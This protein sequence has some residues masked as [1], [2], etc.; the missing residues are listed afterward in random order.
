MRIIALSVVPFVLLGA[1]DDPCEQLAD[2][3]RAK[4]RECDVEID[5]TGERGDETCD[6]EDEAEAAQCLGPC[7]RQAPCG[8]FDGTDMNASIDL[9]QCF[10]QCG[11]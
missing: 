7:Y 2:I 5:D 1:C 9:M 11:Q 3:S 6:N 10:G 8:A 4:A